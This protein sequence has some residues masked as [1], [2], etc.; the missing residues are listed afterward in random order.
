MIKHNHDILVGGNMK[1][2]RLAC[3]M[4]LDDVA[5]I[6][7]IATGTVG[8]IERGTRGATSRNLYKLSK[9]FGVT[10]DSFFA[11]SASAPVV[12]ENEEL[13]NTLVSHVKLFSA[14]ELQ[15]MISTAKSVRT[16]A[17]ERAKHLKE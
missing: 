15:F 14:D 16:M 2:A 10:V 9:A 17:I 3:G 11:D 12:N 1:K 4:S 7:D 8:Q 13:I 6:L 5:K